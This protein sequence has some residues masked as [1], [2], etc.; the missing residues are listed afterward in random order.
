ML[1]DPKECSRD[2]GVLRFSRVGFHDNGA[3]TNWTRPHMTLLRG[4]VLAVT[5][6]FG[7]VVSCR[8]AEADFCQRCG[9]YVCGYPPTYTCCVV[10][11]APGSF[12][13]RSQ[14]VTQKNCKEAG[15]KWKGNACRVR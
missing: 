9:M 1:G 10:Y 2:A 3:K 6:V 11:C 14:P 7:I 5:V 13:K 8:T 12:F 4:S 15:F